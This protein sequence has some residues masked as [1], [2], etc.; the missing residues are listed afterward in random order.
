M[1]DVAVTV[2]GVLFLIVI[3]IVVP[4]A[5]IWF[6]GETRF[7]IPS[8]TQAVRW[9]F[10]GIIIGIA[11]EAYLNSKNI[12]SQFV[13]ISIPLGILIILEY[14]ILR[15]ENEGQKQLEDVLDSQNDERSDRS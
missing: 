3:P 5:L 4:M 11:S 13:W 14:I 1:T 6:R 7:L 10:V 8:I 12:L 15:F 2:F 9:V